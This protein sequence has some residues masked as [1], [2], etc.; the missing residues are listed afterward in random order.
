MFDLIEQSVLDENHVDVEYDEA[1][2]FPVSILVHPDPPPPDSAY[3]VEIRDF[4]IT[5]YR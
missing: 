1:F 4:E 5:E 3:R 2:G